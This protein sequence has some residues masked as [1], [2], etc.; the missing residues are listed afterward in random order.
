MLPIT[1]IRLNW[2]R[3]AKLPLML[4]VLAACP[5]RPPI[6]DCEPGHT[7]C[8]PVSLQPEV[9]SASHR[10]RPTAN[11]SCPEGATCCLVVSIEGGQIHACAP[12]DGSAC[13]EP[14]PGGAYD[15]P[16]APTPTEGAQ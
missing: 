12:D 15:R 13:V 3:L 14:V 7:R 10:W 9:C 6:T 11:E 5:A 4:F 8:G 16:A 2:L 1:V